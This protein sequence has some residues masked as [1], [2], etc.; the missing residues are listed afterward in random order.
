MGPSALTLLV[1][2]GWVV[3]GC[4]VLLFRGPAP[5]LDTLQ[6]QKV[7]GF[8]EDKV[9]LIPNIPGG[10]CHVSFPAIIFIW[11]S[12]LGE[13]KQEQEMQQTA[14]INSARSAMG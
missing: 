12:C 2:W 4:S 11:E 10:R 8:L 13:G 9:L 3:K 7:V 1:W 6:P 5:A 14:L